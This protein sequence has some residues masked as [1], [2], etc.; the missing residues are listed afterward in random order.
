MQRFQN[1]YRESY[2]ESSRGVCRVL[3][4]TINFVCED[5]KP[6]TFEALREVTQDW[7]T[8]GEEVRQYFSFQGI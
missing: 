5:I 3:Q 6:R 2:E 1:D 8:M 7:E 4:E